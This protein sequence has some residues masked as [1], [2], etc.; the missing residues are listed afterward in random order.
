MPRHAMPRDATLH[1]TRRQPA[2]IVILTYMSAAAAAAIKIIEDVPADMGHTQ[3]HG[4]ARTVQRL[5]GNIA[6]M[7]AAIYARRCTPM[8]AQVYA[9]ECVWDTQ[10][11]ASINVYYHLDDVFVRDAGM[12]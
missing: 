4:Y 1:T 9:T 7:T 3:G 5:D 6:F 2:R 8:S 11:I 10:V 12:L